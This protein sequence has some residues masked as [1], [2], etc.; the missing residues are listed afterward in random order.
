MGFDP[1]PD[2]AHTTLRLTRCPLLEAAEKHPDV[3]CAVHLGIARGAMA[4]YGADDS[5]VDLLP[6]A[7][8]GACLLHL[9]H[10]PADQ[11]AARPTAPATG[12][13]A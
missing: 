2:D 10:G 13:N 5:A 8:P 12:E 3:I 7:E 9:A 6:V 11:P 1:R 4:E